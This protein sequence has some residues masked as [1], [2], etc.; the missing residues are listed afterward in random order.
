MWQRQQYTEY[1]VVLEGTYGNLVRQQ[2]IGVFQF[3]EQEVCHAAD[4]G[5]GAVRLIEH[6]LE[7]ER[8]DP[9]P[10][11]QRL[12]L[13]AEQRSRQPNKEPALQVAVKRVPGSPL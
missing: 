3:G 6:W 2:R 10:I 8:S 1:Q 7:R 11:Q 13:P 4:C 5:A 9:L 12:E